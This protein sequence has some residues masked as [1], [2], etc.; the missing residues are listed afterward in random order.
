[1]KI[2]NIKY[3]LNEL[4]QKFAKNFSSPIF[5]VLAESYFRL[6][7]FK[8][9]K[10]VCE[11]GLSQNPDNTLAEHV[12][13]KTCLLEDNYKEAEKL[14]KKVIQNNPSHFQGLML[15]IDVEVFL[16][17]SMETISDHIK[18]AYMI[19]PKNKKIQG[20]YSQLNIKQKK[21]STNYLNK[22]KLKGSILINKK[23]ATKTMYFV[24]IKQKKY[25]D[26]LDLLRT[27]R[28]NKKNK[29]FVKKEYNKVLDL[30]NK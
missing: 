4:E 22:K 18:K 8:K 15:F 14:L 28:E 19:D 5:P 20:L 26:A 23:L 7:K 29:N 1:M 2:R 13:A 12:L 3:S 17:R 6:S 25:S 21:S 10:K 11:L 24:L 30:I 27:M 9:A 16:K